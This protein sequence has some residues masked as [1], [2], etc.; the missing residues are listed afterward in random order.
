[1]ATNETLTG[2][3]RHRI[4][5]HFLRR[6]YSLVLEVEVFYS[7]KDGVYY[8]PDPTD[9][10]LNLEDKSYAYWRDATFADVQELESKK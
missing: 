6:G 3:A 2:R 7:R 4:E 1:M 10:P 9:P 8:G 5:H